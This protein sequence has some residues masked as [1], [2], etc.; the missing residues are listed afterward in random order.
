MSQICQFCKGESITEQGLRIGNECFCRY[1]CY[2][3]QYKLEDGVY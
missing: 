1:E 2:D 3:S